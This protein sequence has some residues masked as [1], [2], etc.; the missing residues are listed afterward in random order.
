MVWFKVDD[1]FATHQKTVMA[2]NRAIGL[3]VRAG[4][5]CSAQLTD[6][7]VPEHMISVLGG[8][9]GDARKLVATGLWVE[10]PNG[11]RFHQWNEDGR[12]PT[13]QTVE[14]K[15]AEDRQRKADARAAKAAANVNG[16]QR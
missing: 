13:R 7:F 5:W 2:G 4:S 11:Y 6:G 16:H 3:W 8:Q 9:A 10:A 14:Q 1:Q 12:Q 15:R